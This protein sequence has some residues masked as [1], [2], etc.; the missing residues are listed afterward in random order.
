V[1]HTFTIREW[2][3]KQFGERVKRTA[4]TLTSISV[5]APAENTAAMSLRTEDPGGNQILERRLRDR[6]APR[7]RRR[8]DIFGETPRLLLIEPDEATRLLYA[9]LFEEA[10][11]AVYPMAEGIGAI[12]VVRGRLPDVVVME[13]AVPG[14]DG[15]EILRQLRE[16]PLTSSI[17]AVVV[18][19]VL[20]FDVPEHARASGA[21]LVLGK[22]TGPE[23]LLAEVDEL[24]RATPRE[25]LV[26]RQLRRSLL[27]LREL[28]KR[29][30]PEER[31]QERVRALIDRLQVAILALDAQGCYVAVSRGASTLTGYSRA[32]LL[33]RSI[34]DAGLTLNPP[35]SE[36]WQEFLAQQR[37]GAETKMRDRNGNI[38][39]I[40]TEF[41]TILPGLHAAAFAGQPTERTV[42]PSA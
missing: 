36:G 19:S 23:T 7:G 37:S 21:V 29:V 16:D 31:A 33:G 42:N 5:P 11:Y 18:T 14:A 30:K 10:G 6:R 22:P 24:I 4:R 40:Q 9:C 32:E 28:G 38:V 20:N 34:F 35:A 17:P 3:F 1:E 25:R 2:L 41:A 12:D 26:V 39:R 8:S 27:T 13:L 15:F